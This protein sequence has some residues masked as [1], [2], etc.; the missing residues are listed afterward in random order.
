M[1]IIKAH[2]PSVTL[3]SNDGD[4][5][6]FKS[7]SDALKQLGLSWIRE[8][9]AAEFVAYRYNDRLLAYDATRE[10]EVWISRPVYRHAEYVMRDDTGAKLTPADFRPL[11]GYGAKSWARRYWH[12]WESWSGE[13][14][15][16]GIGRSRGGHGHRRL[17]TFGERRDAQVLEDEVPPRGKR[18]VRNVPNPYDDYS[19]ST[20]GVRSWKRFRKTQWK[21]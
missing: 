11:K 8:N 1:H 4:V 2:E 13:G 12:M 18:S 15:V 20:W 16:P 7:R 21:A 9:V 3:F 19:I 17:R 6:V 5:R 10:R 14:Q